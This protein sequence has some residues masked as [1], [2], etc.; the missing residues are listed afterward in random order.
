MNKIDG[1]IS[2]FQSM[3]SM[4]KED[5]WMNQIHP[6]IKLFLTVLFIGLTVSFPK[7]NLTGLFGMIAAHCLY[8]RYCQSVF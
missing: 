7:Y 8:R 6:S 4:A 3:D 2:Q 1:A 5:R